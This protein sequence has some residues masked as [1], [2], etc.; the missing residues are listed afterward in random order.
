MTTETAP[1]PQIEAWSDRL[2]EELTEAGMEQVQARAY[3]RAF[4][5]GLT[6]VISQVATR[7]ELQD[8]LA[9]S[10]QELQDGLAQLRQELHAAVAQ[11]RQ[12]TNQ[13]RAD[14]NGRM[15]RFE[16]L[17]YWAAGAGLGL[18]VALVVRSFTA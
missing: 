14:L 5:L 17:F 13:L 16:R 2:E 10:R 12:E 6:R 15:D 11:L 4:E 9:L 18:L 1:D 8:G 7:K 3:R